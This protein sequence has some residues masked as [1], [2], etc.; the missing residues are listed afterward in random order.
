MMRA[1]GHHPISRQDEVSRVCVSLSPFLSLSVY[2]YVC[3]CVC[4]YACE[5]IHFVII[6]F[7]VGK[8]RAFR[9]S[10]RKRSMEFRVYCTAV[11]MIMCPCGIAMLPM[12]REPP[13]EKYFCSRSH[14]CHCWHSRT[15]PI[16][17]TNKRSK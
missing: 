6:K 10:E 5:P 9:T 17:W 8:A 15:N 16:S 2:K 14:P 3:V 11:I 4:G 1:K 7:S 12:S 13:N